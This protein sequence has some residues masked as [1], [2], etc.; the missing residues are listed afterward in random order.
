LDNNEALLS[1]IDEKFAFLDN[2]ITIPQ[3]LILNM[4]NEFDLINR[5]KIDNQYMAELANLSE[6]N[7]DHFICERPSDCKVL[8]KCTILVGKTTMKFL[9]TYLKKGITPA[10]ELLDSFINYCEEYL[11][12]GKCHDKTCMY[13]L[14]NGYTSLRGLLKANQIITDDMTSNLLNKKHLYNI[15]DGSEKEDSKLLTPLSNELRIK[16]LKIVSKGGIYYSQLEREIGLKGGSFHFHLEKLIEGGYVTQESE[17]G[18]Y[19]A[20]IN[21]LRA[22]KFIF[23]LKKQFLVNLYKL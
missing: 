10:Q 2:K 7:L 14:I 5:T 16:I 9:N 20:T 19:I 3:D 13:N 17:K 8:D 22:L 1:K 18:P 12:A 4:K 6:I 23:E 21:G 15:L 11:N